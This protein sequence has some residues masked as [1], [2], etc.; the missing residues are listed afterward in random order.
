[1]EGN[2]VGS[3]VRRKTIMELNHK[4]LLQKAALF[5]DIDENECAR[6]INCLSP[7]V[8][9]F[10]KN[11][12]ILSTGDYV[13]HIGII[14][15]GNACANLEHMDGSQTIMSNLVPMSVFGEVLVSTRTHK[16]PVT[17]YATSDVT[18]AYIDYQKVCSMCEAAC[19]AHRMFLKNVLKA[20]G[21][22]YFLLF[23]RINI[24]REKSLRSKIMAYLYALS[25][26]GKTA[27]VTIPFTKTMLADYLLVNRSA[28]SKELRQME[29]DGVIAV[30]GRKIEIKSRG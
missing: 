7:Y 12:I 8:R 14:L 1:M 20:I 19:A 21:D 17:V 28:L 15:Y 30:N 4:R 29:C 23:D 27:I 26:G 18:A 25:D 3:D 22:K 9:H 10:S 11:E 24:L 16:S 13:H 6:M 5:K 2:D